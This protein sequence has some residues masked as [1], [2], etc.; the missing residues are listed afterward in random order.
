MIFRLDPDDPTLFPRPELAEPDGLLAVGGD[1]GPE[2]MVAAYAQGIFPWFNEPPYLWWSPDPRFILLPEN[3]HIPRR[4]ERVLHSGRFTLTMN[5]DFAAVCRGCAESPRPGQKGTWITP[6]MQQAYGQLHKLG[7]AHSFEAWKDGELAGGMY[8]VCLGQAFFAESMFYR[9]PEAS[10]SALA[11]FARWF[12]GRGGQ[13]IDCQQE[14]AHMRRF[15]ATTVPRETFLE[16]LRTART[17][18]LAPDPRGFGR[19]GSP[20]A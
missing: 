3:L 6:E 14:S 17:L 10:K 15:G 4:L 8:G 12:F 18:P 11:A 1:L 9:E 13:F 20:A 16:R 7:L 2:R 19:P 5:E